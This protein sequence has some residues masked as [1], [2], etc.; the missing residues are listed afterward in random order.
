MERTVSKCVNFAPNSKRYDG[1]SQVSAF[2]PPMRNCLEA[3]SN[4]REA[5]TNALCDILQVPAAVEQIVH[6][7]FVLRTLRTAE[8]LDTALACIGI[9]GTEQQLQ[10]TH[11]AAY[12]HILKLIEKLSQQERGKSC[13]V[14]PAS[15]EPSSVSAAADLSREQ[16]SAVRASPQ[17]QRKRIREESAAELVLEHAVQSP[18]KCSKNDV[19]LEL[20]GRSSHLEDALDALRPELT[21]GRVRHASTANLMEAPVSHCTCLLQED[22]V[23]SCARACAASST[24]TGAAAGLAALGQRSADAACGTDCTCT[25]QG[26]EA[27]IGSPSTDDDDAASGSTDNPT[28]SLPDAGWRACA[29]HTPPGCARQEQQGIPDQQHALPSASVC[30]SDVESADGTPVLPAGG[31]RAMKIS[32]GHLPWLV[33]LARLQYFH[34]QARHHA[35]MARAARGNMCVPGGI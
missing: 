8:D 31:G 10:T 4:A 2:L 14:W 28:D 25:G 18:A 7:A 32:T 11:I 24:S 26:G 33:K 9:F 3:L 12:K 30:S 23:P 20:P 35:M 27:D 13:V 34:I 22:P 19:N 1:L 21:R 15:N 5:I 29:R 16:S 17:L 6:M